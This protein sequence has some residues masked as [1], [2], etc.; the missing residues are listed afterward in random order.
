MTTSIGVPVS[1][2]RQNAL[3]AG[4][5]RD[6]LTSTAAA[7]LQNSGPGKATPQASSV[8]QA[9]QKTP[10]DSNESRPLIYSPAGAWFRDDAT[11]AVRYR[12]AAHA[13][14]VLIGW[15]ET[16]ASTPNLADQPLAFAAFKELSSQ[17]APGLCATCH[18]MDQ[19]ESGQF[20][21]NWR[22][23]D[24]AA[25]PRGFTKFSHGP[26]LLLPQLADCTQCHAID[27]RVAAT[28]THAGWDPHR[29]ASEFIPMSKRQCAECHTAEAA[30]DRCQKCH[31]YHV[32]AGSGIFESR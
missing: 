17:T 4:L 30:G 25:E 26:H 11:F 9:S 21:I 2:S 20:S 10:I 7:W 24:R 28:S 32:E 14:P 12:P 31:N 22:A 3:V 13:D 27:N 16:L 8:D 5:S 15:L 19:S 6:T 18:S 1:K 23:Y 29:F